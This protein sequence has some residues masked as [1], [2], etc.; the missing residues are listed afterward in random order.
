MKKRSHRFDIGI[1]LVLGVV[2]LGCALA[3]NEWVYGD[4]KC[5]FARCVKV[6][7]IKP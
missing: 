3:W 2:I 7:N 4:W 5:T 6:E 1:A